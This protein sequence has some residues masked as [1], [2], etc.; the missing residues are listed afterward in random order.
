[1]VSVVSS[2]AVS[3]VTIICKQ[4]TEHAGRKYVAGQTLTVSADE[5]AALTAGGSFR[6]YPREH[7][8]TDR[9]MHPEGIRTP[10]GGR[11]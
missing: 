10:E 4:D 7:A 11:E 6:V 2:L 9:E 3:L 5:A 8:R 1:M